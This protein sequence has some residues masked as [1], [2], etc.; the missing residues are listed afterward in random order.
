M[1]KTER[2]AGVIVFRVDPQTGRRLYLLLDYG[3][4]WDLPKGHVEPAEDDHAAAVRELREETGLY[5][6]RFLPDFKREIRYFFRQART[7]V[8]KTVVFFLAQTDQTQLVLSAEHVGGEF[9]EYEAAIKRLKYPSARELLRF[10]EEAAR[11]LP[12]D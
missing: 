5:D 8:E 12:G 11:A 2:S 1:R 6:V 10:A 4:Y 3:P 7:L 9:V